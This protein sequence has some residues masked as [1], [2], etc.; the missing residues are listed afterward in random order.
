[1][2]KHSSGG[3]ESNAA[4]SPQWTFCVVTLGRTMTKGHLNLTFWNMN[5][6]LNASATCKSRS[7]NESSAKGE[8]LYIDWD[9][10]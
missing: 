10:E 4:L 9:M 2:S 3:E 1:M 5:L 8:P 6:E 7:E